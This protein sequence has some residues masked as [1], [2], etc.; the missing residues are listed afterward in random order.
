VPRRPL[1]IGY[2]F[3]LLVVVSLPAAIPFTSKVALGHHIYHDE[4]V[5]KI[6]LWSQKIWELK[7]SDS[8]AIVISTM[9]GK[10]ASFLKS[11]WN[12]TNI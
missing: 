10:N 2:V 5:N 7:V 9:I 8:I 3:V 6:S 1:G 4:Y 12:E 11:S